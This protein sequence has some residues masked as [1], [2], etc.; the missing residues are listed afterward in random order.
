VSGPLADL[1]RAGVAM[2]NAITRDGG[3]QVTVQHY[4]AAAATRDVFG[5]PA[6]VA[7]VTRQALVTY[8]TRVVANATGGTTVSYAQLVFLEDVAISERDRLVL[9]Q[10]TGPI[11][12]IVQMA[13]PAGR[14]F[15][16]EVWLGEL[17]G[18]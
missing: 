7:P 2:A 18:S 1:V 8:E 5:K 16:T 11:V 17:Q 12:K 13:D 15:L 14:G 3:L 10:A 6:P 9:G 4:P